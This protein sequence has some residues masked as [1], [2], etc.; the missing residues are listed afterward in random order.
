MEV[1]EVKVAKDAEV[2]PDECACLC[3]AVDGGGDGGG[4][5]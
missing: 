3:S 2:T 4:D 1:F 5:W